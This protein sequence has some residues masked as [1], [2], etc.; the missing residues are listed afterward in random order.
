[1]NRY[2]DE[3]CSEKHG[4]RGGENKLYAGF[5]GEG[6]KRGGVG[7][8][9]TWK[10]FYPFFFLRSTGELSPSLSLG[11]LIQV[12]ASLK[13]ARVVIRWVVVHLID[14]ISSILNVN[15]L[16]SIIVHFVIL[17]EV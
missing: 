1:M 6:K 16:R 2:K 4:K 17:R 13:L 15:K 5:M 3:Y 7:L 10:I 11:A 14:S 12:R 8:E 9:F